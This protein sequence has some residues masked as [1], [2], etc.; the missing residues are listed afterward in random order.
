[1]VYTMDEIKQIISPVAEKY[2]LRA[3][4][5]FG[6]YAKGTATESSDI[7]LLIDT[8]GTSIKSLLQLSTVYCD[9]EE[10]L[11]KKVDVLTLGQLTLNKAGLSISGRPINI[12]CLA[13][14]FRRFQL[15][16]CGRRRDVVIHNPS[17]PRSK[18]EPYASPLPGH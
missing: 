15:F 7:D 11:G 18:S 13:E 6:S 2:H 4:Y 3:V 10:A 5:L 9:L 1:M 16:P 8:T 12:G 17:L 14:G